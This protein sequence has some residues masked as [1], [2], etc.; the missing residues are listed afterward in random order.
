MSV[1]YNKG[2]W[3]LYQFSMAQCTGEWAKMLRTKQEL[4]IRAGWG[5]FY[6]IRINSVSAAQWLG[7]W[8][9]DWL[10]F[11]QHSNCLNIYIQN[12]VCSTCILRAIYF[13]SCQKTIF[14]LA[15]LVF[16]SDKMTNWFSAINHQYLHFYFT[17][18]RNRIKKKN[19]FTLIVFS[20]L[21]L[22]RYR[23]NCFSFTR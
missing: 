4:G 18:N 10:R 22:Y 19:T 2:I 16:I 6:T 11:L 23:V 13:M 1:A 21:K 3:K 5:E 9:S 14:R 15:V 20:H 7:A 12:I 17:I 8:F